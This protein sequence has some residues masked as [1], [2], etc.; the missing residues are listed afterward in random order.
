MGQISSKLP[1]P[2]P[3]DWG[4]KVSV[5]IAV[6]YSGVGHHDRLILVTDNR[7]AFGDFSGEYLTI[8][9][10]ALWHGWSV[11]FAGNQVEHA[12][13]IIR[14]AKQNMMALSKKLPPGKWISP[15]EATGIVDVAYAEQL[16][17][18]IENKILRK[19]GFDS[20]NFQKI[21]KLKCTPEIYAKTWERID[22]EK[23]SLRF[24]VCG[25]EGKGNAHIWLVDG[26]NAP[27][28][29]NSIGFWAIGTGAP[30]AISHLAV[31]LTKYKEFSSLEEALYVTVTAKFSAESASDVGRS[32]NVFIIKHQWEADDA[33]HLPEPML[34]LLRKTWNDTGI[35]PVPKG[36]LR[37]LKKVL[38]VA[39]TVTT[40][41][42][43]QFSRRLLNNHCN[44]TRELW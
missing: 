40:Q 2:R 36:V 14:A 9:S 19:H 37:A 34:D 10:S 3:A 35:P 16:Q 4:F 32:T 12:E 33:I 18:H 13:P 20:A 21:G 23:L 43:E 39:A 44:S 8:K 5:C 27:T 15:E 26:E 25:H 29:Y 22:K 6:R 24:L 11:M 31:Y 28:S 17:A 42:A 38:P 1:V 7:A 41:M 30:A